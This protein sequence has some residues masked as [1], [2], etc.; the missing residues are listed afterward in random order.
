M[1]EH[2]RWDRVF[3]ATSL[4]MKQINDVENLGL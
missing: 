4:E 2:E 3:S 1:M